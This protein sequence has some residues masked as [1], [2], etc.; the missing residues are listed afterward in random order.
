MLRNAAFVLHREG[1]TFGVSRARLCA[2]L[3]GEAEDLDHVWRDAIQ[4]R[5][6]V[7]NELVLQLWLLD[8]RVGQL[9]GGQR[10]QHG[11]RVRHRNLA[12]PDE[13]RPELGQVPDASLDQLL[14]V[15]ADRLRELR[16]VDQRLSRWRAGGWV[17]NGAE[18]SKRRLKKARRGKR[19][20]P[21]GSGSG[22]KTDFRWSKSAIV[23]TEVTG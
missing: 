23:E 11:Q 12:A 13:T 17:G 21:I 1:R 20:G 6:C 5:G 10:Q 22:C 15:R 4:V 3:V 18:E 8:H 14:Q 19:E 9:F 7:A 16:A 2:S